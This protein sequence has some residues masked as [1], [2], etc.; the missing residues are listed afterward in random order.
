MSRTEDDGWKE[1]LDVSAW[2]QHMLADIGGGGRLSI[3]PY[4]YKSI[5]HTV[6]H[7]GS[8]LF[9]VPSPLHLYPRLLPFTG[10]TFELFSSKYFLNLVLFTPWL[11]LPA[12]LV[13]LASSLDLGSL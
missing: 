13:F 8:Q 10:T 12:Q 6:S 4:F 3:V 2:S 5:L 11:H 1:H 7:A 9:L